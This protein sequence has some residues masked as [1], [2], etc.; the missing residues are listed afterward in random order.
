M[1]ITDSHTQRV[2]LVTR[3]GGG[4]E[5]RKETEIGGGELR[6]GEESEGDSKR[7]RLNL[8]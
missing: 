7:E 6:R 5:R 3:R 1:T 4:G 8:S 2:G